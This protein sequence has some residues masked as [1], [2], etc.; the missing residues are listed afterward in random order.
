LCKINVSGSLSIHHFLQR[1]DWT[2]QLGLKLEIANVTD[3]RQRVRDATG[4]VP[5]RYQPDLLDAVGRSVV[6]SL[7]KLF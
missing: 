2:R 7:R 3:A 6:F 5:Y 1:Q 4:V